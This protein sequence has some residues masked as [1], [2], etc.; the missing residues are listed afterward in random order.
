MVDYNF[1]YLYLTGSSLCKLSNSNAFSSTPIGGYSASAGTYGSIYVPASL[2]TSYQTA[3]NWAYFSSRFV[4]YDGGANII[5]FT[6]EGTEYQAEE[7]MT[8]A[9]WVESEYNTGDAE[10]TSYGSIRMA[11]ETGEI[12]SVRDE[13]Y[14]R[15]IEASETIIEG[16]N[17][18]LE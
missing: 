13:Y 17:Y 4:A 3:T 15:V 14:T 9:E 6:I 11:Y 18:G 12:C 10:I 7:G 2:L 8:W 16:Y 1:K 5:T